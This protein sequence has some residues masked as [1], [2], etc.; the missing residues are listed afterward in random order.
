MSP[1]PHHT[2]TDEELLGDLFLINAPWA[3]SVLWKVIRG[4]VDQKTAN[5]FHVLGSDYAPTLRRC[6]ARKRARRGAPRRRR[7]CLRPP[8]AKGV[9]THW[10]DVAGTSRRPTCR[11]TTVA[12]GRRFR[13]STGTRCPRSVPKG[14]GAC[15]S[16][17]K[18]SSRR[19]SRCREAGHGFA[20]T[21]ARAAL[22]AAPLHRHRVLMR[23]WAPVRAAHATG[24]G[25]RSC[26]LLAQ[27]S[28]AVRIVGNRRR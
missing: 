6:E 27:Q 4:W 15:G 19:R 8:Q 17:R 22:S 7:C 23:A 21:A 2:H 11:A 26:A 3:F 5:K 12:R 13:P 24:A 14:R 28:R 18:G 25:A 9:V 10:G 16:R 20:R 1:S